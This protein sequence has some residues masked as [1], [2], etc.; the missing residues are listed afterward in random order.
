MKKKD[1][2]QSVAVRFS[3]EPI[4]ITGIGCR[5]PG[6]ANSAG[7]FWNML[8]RGV[9]AVSEVPPD[10]WS[11]PAYYDPVPGRPGK[12]CSKWG[13]FIADIDKF[14]PAFFSLSPREAVSMDP[15]QR[16][17]LEVTWEAM[18][19]AGQVLDLVRG[20]NIG[21]FVGVSTND[22]SS[23]QWSNDDPSKID[24]YTTTGNATS[25]IANRISYCFNLTGPSIA[26]DT[27]CSSSLTA[28][29]LA[30]R[31]LQNGDC[32]M[33]LV[34]GVNA[35][36]GPAPYLSFSRMGMLSPEGKCK[37]FDRDANGFV[38]GEGSGAVLLKPL[39][40]AL[41]SGDR[42]YAVIRAIAANQDGRTNGITVPNFEAQKR[43][44]IDACRQAG[45]DPVDVDYIEA[46]GTGT[47]V[48]D[49]IEAHAIGGALGAN[50]PQDRPCIVGSVKTN[51]GHQEAGS[52]VAGLIK[53]ALVLKHGKVPPNLH[54]NNPNPRIDFRKLGLR[55]PTAI[56]ELPVRGR[57]WLA[58]VNSFGFGGANAHAVLEAPPAAP[59]EKTGSDGGASAFFLPLSA[60]TPEALEKTGIGYKI[61]LETKP[62]A[63]LDRI[64][65]NAGHRRNHHPYRAGVV[66]A[67]RLE[68]IE[69]LESVSTGFAGQAVA[70]GQASDA[71]RPGPV[72]VFS[73]QGP[74]W[75]GM[76][77]ELMQEEP[78]FRDR[79][80]KCGAIITSLGGWSL[81]EE[82]SMD[83]QSSRLNE[84]SIAQPAIF[85]IQM[86][87][88]DLLASWGV[89]P[90]AV[91]GHSVGE[92]AAACV[93]GAIDFEDAVKVIFHRGRCMDIPTQRGKMLAA[94][95]SADEAVKLAE[96]YPGK[97]S[98]GAINAPLSVTLSGD[99]ASLEEIA[100]LLEK[101]QVFA[102]F[103][104]VNYAFHSS[105]MDPVRDELLKSLGHFETRNPKILLYSTVTGK[106]AAEGDFGPEYWW[107]N[108]RQ[109]VRFS[110]AIILIASG[111]HD[112]FLE[113]SPQPVLATSI[114]ECLVRSGAVATVLPTLRRREKERMSLLSS[115]ARL[116]ERGFEINW[117]GPYS[118]RRFFE[119]L[120]LYQW[121]RDS[122]W[123]EAQLC[124][125]TRLHTPSG[126]LLGMRLQT[127]SP[128]WQVN[129]DVSE[130]AYFT[131]HKVQGKQV[132]P[133]AGY[134]E[135][136]CEAGRSMFGQSVVSVEDLD[137]MRMLVLPPPDETT[138][139]R[140]NCRNDD[141]SFAVTGR[142]A[143][144]AGEW[145]LYAAGHIIERKDIV[146][147]PF[148]DM[149][150]L[151]AGWYEVDVN[152]DV[153]GK[154]REAGLDYGP[155]FRGL[156]RMWIGKGEAVGRVELC[157]EQAAETSRY[158]V[159][160]ALL[161][162]CLQSIIGVMGP[163]SS[164][165][166]LP[167]QAERIRCYSKAGE[168][169]WCMARLVHQGGRT[170][171]CDLTIA[172]DDGSVV[173]Q[174]EGFRCLQVPE[175]RKAEADR[176]D[177]F[178]RPAWKTLAL[179]AG[180]GAPA[181]RVLLT[182]LNK[183]LPKV[184][185]LVEFL[186]KEGVDERRTRMFKKR[187]DHLCMLYVL[188]TFARLG[189]NLS[190]ADMF[191]TA[192]L[193]L[194]L[195]VDPAQ[196]KYTELLL[197]I[198]EK[199]GMLKRKN[200]LWI[201][202]N[203]PSKFNVDEL[204]RQLVETGP[205]MLPEITLLRRCGNR[206]DE[207]LSGK[208]DGLQ[209]LF[210]DGSSAEME[211]LYQSSEAFRNNNRVAAEI[212]KQAIKG[213]TDGR[214][215][216]VLEVGA[217]TGG[218]TSYVAPILPPHSTEYFFTDVSNFFFAQAE[219]K[220]FEHKFLQY[221]VLDI[222]KNPGEQGYEPASF[223]IVLA[224][225]VVHAT[226]DVREALSNIRTL[227]KP[228]AMFVMLE[229]EAPPPWVD[230]VF[231][232]AKGWWRFSDHDLRPSHPLL[233]S[234]QWLGSLDK[235]GFV[236]ASALRV[237]SRYEGKGHV[238]LIAQ[239]P[240]STIQGTA[241]E[242]TDKL[243][244]P[245]STWVILGDRS[246]AGGSFRN[247]LRK[248]GQQVVFASAGRKYDRK[249]LDVT[250]RAGCPEDFG[251]MI[252]DITSMNLPPVSNVF[253]MW[254]LDFC[255]Q[256][257]ITRDLIGKALEELSIGCL[258][259]VQA[260]VAGVPK[261]ASRLWIVT[262]GTEPLEGD[263]KTAIAASELIGM[264][265]VIAC[266]LPKLQCKLIDLDPAGAGNEA[267]IL[268]A[269]SI[270]PDNDREIAYRD[271]YRMVCRLRKCTPEQVLKPSEKNGFRLEAPH[272]GAL[273]RLE[274]RSFGL[275]EPGCGEVR[276]EVE[277]AALNFRDV[278][279]ALGVYPGD[280]DAYLML[281]DEC[282]G[283]VLETGPGVTGF[284]RGDRVI[285]IGGGCYASEIVVPEASVIPAP[286]GMT[287]AELVTIPVAFLTA[288]YAL[289]H[290]G[291]VKKGDK[292][293]IQAATG[294]VGL[295]AVQVARLAGAEVFA[296]AGSPEKR[297]FLK[298]FGV[299]HIMDSRSLAFADAV[300]SATNRRG[301]D[302][303]L[304]SL[305]GEAIREGLSVLAP[306]GRFI[307]IGKRDIYLN[308][309]IGLRAFR[310]NAS[311]S[312]IDL[313]QVMADEPK[314]IK[315][316]MASLIKDFKAGRLHPLPMRI[317]PISQIVTAFRNMSQAKH[318]GKVV[319]AGLCHD[320]TPPGPFEAKQ[321]TI[322]K[323]AAY[324]ITGGFGGFGLSMA[325]WL[326]R[327]GA[328]NL[329]LLGR[330]GAGTE[331]AGAK[332][333]AL[334]KAGATVLCVR[335]DVSKSEDVVRA[336]A[337]AGKKMPP[338]AGIIHAAMVLDDGI[339][340]HITAER[341]LRVAEP[342]IM[343]VWN[344][345]EQ[346]AKMKLDFFVMF[347]S[348]SSIV[349][350]RGQ[351]SYV[352]ANLFLDVF[353]AYRKQLGL[354]ALTINWG[355]IGDVG[356]VARNRKII[357]MLGE[358]GHK[359]VSSVEAADA[360][361]YLMNG[362]TGQFCISRT[363]WRKL[364]SELKSVNLTERF[365]ELVEKE[366]GQ[367]PEKISDK[368]VI[369]AIQAAPAGEKHALAVSALREQIARILRVPADKFD[370]EKP[371]SEAGLDSLMAVEMGL[372]VE[373]MFSVTIPPGRLGSSISTVKL[374]EIILE[375]IGETSQPAAGTA[376]PEK[377][378][379]G[380]APEN[381]DCLIP[382]RPEGAGVP[383]F[384]VHPT[385][386]VAS[387]YNTLA[388][389]LAPGTPVYFI[390]SRALCSSLPEHAKL[391]DLVKDYAGQI[392][393]IAGGSGVKVAG[394]SFGGMLALEI[395]RELEQR[396]VKVNAVGLIDA[397]ENWAD[398]MSGTDK[399]LTGLFVELYLM[400]ARQMSAVKTMDEKC[401]SEE[402]EKIAG[403]VFS[404]PFEK[405]ADAAVEWLDAGG[406]VA[407]NMPKSLIKTYF[408]IF[409]VHSAMLGSFSQSRISAP[410]VLWKA[411][412]AVIGGD[413]VIQFARL[414][415][416]KFSLVKMEC[417]HYEMLS[418]P[419]VDA[420]AR[421]MEEVFLP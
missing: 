175:T 367:S 2:N 88:A 132:F 76:G 160:P 119:D 16:L 260:L 233:A 257:K 389:R 298:G 110:D 348:I 171:I 164:K 20:T 385:G 53:A 28:L 308:S 269:E 265:R 328:G 304:N 144:N 58:G 35:I 283:T 82:L 369:E 85:S 372:M 352:A 124:R 285:V 313:A 210:P 54:F 361:A 281:G 92:A 74:Q 291:H 135:M 8:C 221:L 165:L 23:L 271:G 334:E 309:R 36:L 219:Q 56:E 366:E 416:D 363:D 65:W 117:D 330:S 173:M 191:T 396:E 31:S 402:I 344:L 27:A 337:E 371:L 227:M 161:D 331:D 301:V 224:S 409:N 61:F 241:G 353:A 252:S 78:V 407:R 202:G 133:A 34:A 96:K 13:G 143:K 278:L 11:I 222:E 134:I 246:G 40:D 26:V 237:A 190:R 225:D 239:A 294:G 351:V 377:G 177:L 354:P 326:V 311:F 185:S 41:A 125:H 149:E 240:E 127:P 47:Q 235:V 81:V 108:V 391:E 167:V 279:K 120:P 380:V 136:A 101:R 214:L 399:S 98:I 51:I 384:L 327:R 382:V 413:G 168:G 179:P 46:H 83:E 91:V 329:V 293:L 401:L 299:K 131:D 10:R 418:P 405:R 123:N 217:G 343:G 398:V 275:R 356:Y 322:R 238:L 295:A 199:G 9:D 208:L 263:G 38:R 228:G 364:H 256:K 157:P 201:A 52:G 29:H 392:T 403:R 388:E 393:A 243:Q 282:A 140:L 17:L 194:R 44:V 287:F 258:H 122:F 147:P 255:I 89:Y 245:V 103:L 71:G 345:H 150:S 215:I 276:I 277:T 142:A 349:G 386:G 296:T 19:D 324:M 316:I 266:E 307:E 383:L 420:L 86:A 419:H 32:K 159:H 193:A 116:Y 236:N 358:Q 270:A 261:E 93:A 207:V 223:D 248:E 317:F 59:T 342:K 213:C 206:M 5:Y 247:K 99:P 286:P 319:V 387:G 18:E 289:H 111:G 12:S 64:C 37:S 57:P 267:E 45:I 129:V 333:A 196:V 347:S 79:I 102:K 113:L 178:C 172:N 375:M 148:A 153:F 262:R 314:L 251:R 229:P 360:M 95:I 410:I 154:F 323:N 321:V 128:A 3:N 253:F 421:S 68:L 376:G 72:F 1:N 50:R 77:R 22:Y 109:T 100:V 205:G 170:I 192:E 176:R 166:Y 97:V 338:L 355:V 42:I 62:D 138:Q 84:T 43:L 70:S 211:H 250:V 350:N 280:R 218:M 264:A 25:I 90:S 340:E 284:R 158:V 195:S 63:D 315:G 411:S 374:A 7:Q 21:V 137:F 55:I 49:P 107:K 273:E 412:H 339:I 115:L 73:G 408:E 397:N 292:V 106:K 130:F 318:I 66:G 390:Q 297:D 379:A 189:W 370:A 121:N 198:L 184:R 87:L 30:F 118:S 310:N 188:R 381:I 302:I 303:I 105:Y 336:F 203:I 75:W 312:S 272:P 187:F 230:I 60:R 254:P 244:L 4:A 162:A 146:S 141:S 400:F 80:E 112:V 174:I 104:Y 234:K 300:R 15:Q 180:P 151:R 209:L 6:G 341:F 346:S 362:G 417:G 94:G 406:F 332:V 200:D 212:V 145:T 290:V 181:G 182:P 404:L 394:F 325:E 24:I 274:F 226:K 259:L 114:R 216:K 232:M 288:H 14:D 39:A 414:T 139:L 152:Q 186:K 163:S 335:A 359:T 378:R 357:E 204:W 368:R 415:R 373:E 220:F 155:A 126:T 231:G 395:A 67:N 69:S 365:S 156:K 183:I 197:G 305:A 48:G 320:P 249:G 268:F 169:A 33:A 306:Y 242:I